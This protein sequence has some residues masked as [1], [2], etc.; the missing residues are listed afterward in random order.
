MDQDD[1]LLDAEER[2]E[3]ATQVLQE[4]LQGL[5]TGR[6]TPGLVDS[7]RVDYYGSATPLKQLAN[8]SIPEPQQIVIKPF[9]ANVIGEITKAIQNSN[10][11]LAPNSDGRLIRLNVPPLST[12][13]RKQLVGRVKELAEQ[14]R[15]SIRNIRRDANKHADQSEK[16]KLFSEDERNRVKSEIQDLTKKYEANVNKAASAKEESIM[17]D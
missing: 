16:E 15:V 11:G 13:R 3:K 6:A 4:G 2:M 5:R 7:I 17:D 1:I 8:I 12:E 10:I 9:D 14:A